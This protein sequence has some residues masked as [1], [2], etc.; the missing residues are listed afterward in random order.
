M[1]NKNKKSYIIADRYLPNA[2]PCFTQC[3][4]YLAVTQ[5][6]RIAI[7]SRTLIRAS[8]DEIISKDKNHT[9]FPIENHER[10]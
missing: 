8:F 9:G 5:T 6:F 4:V 1:E 10:D 2:A 3:L 7:K